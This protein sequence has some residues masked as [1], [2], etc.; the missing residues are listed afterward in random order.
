MPRINFAK[1]I[2]C[3]NPSPFLRLQ[4]FLKNLKSEVL[5]LSKRGSQSCFYRYHLDTNRVL[6]CANHVTSFYLRRQLGAI[7]ITIMLPNR[8]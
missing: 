1:H 3:C 7:Q 8:N 4:K 6:C 5:P 2:C